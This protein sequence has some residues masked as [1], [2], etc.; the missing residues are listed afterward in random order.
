M[1]VKDP[2]MWPERLLLLSR[3]SLDKKFK[4]KK[5]VTY[6]V[7]KNKKDIVNLMTVHQAN[8]RHKISQIK[9]WPIKG[10]EW[11]ATEFLA[12][13]IMGN[14]GVRNYKEKKERNKKKVTPPAGKVHYVPH[15][16][17]VSLLSVTTNW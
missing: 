8:I 11:S 4:N 1:V 9:G 5:N 13:E 10:F 6:K 17:H 2:G 3:L 12:T 15:K 14:S 7:K 16:I